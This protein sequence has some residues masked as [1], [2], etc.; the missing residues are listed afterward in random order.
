MTGVK[1]FMTNAQ[2]TEFMDKHMYKAD[3]VLG[4]CLF[5]MFFTLP[6][7]VN[8]IKSNVIGTLVGLSPILLGFVYWMCNYIRGFCDLWKKDVDLTY[9][10]MVRE[11]RS[12]QHES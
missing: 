7:S 12:E 9:E 2:R 11:A 5:I 3:K 8:V 1:R 10:R 4:V 6:V